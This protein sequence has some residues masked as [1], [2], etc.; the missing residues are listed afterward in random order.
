[1]GLVIISISVFLIRKEFIRASNLGNSNFSG[2][3]DSNTAEV[4]NY[5][6]NIEKTIDEMNSSFYGIVSDLEGKYSVHEKEIRVIDEKISEL[7]SLSISIS[8]LLKIQ[9]K[10]ISII[11]EKEKKLLDTSRKTS[12][13][14]I[15]NES[16]EL[17]KSNENIIKSNK[18]VDLKVKEIKYKNHLIGIA[19]FSDEKNQLKEE[20]I[21]LHALGYDINN[22]ARQL[23][24]G[25]RE[26]KMLLN[27]TKK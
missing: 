19:D 25:T 6:G 1:M 4:L 18:E 22:I 27:F 12:K 9:G 21:K 26:V 13:K 5:L 10:E 8:K 16:S 15:I 20:V 24:R 7:N 2:L 23:N 3:N 17:I 14:S 11:L